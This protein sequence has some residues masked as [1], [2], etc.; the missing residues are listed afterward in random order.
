MWIDHNFSA[1]FC[2]RFAADAASVNNRCNFLLR[3][4]MALA[5][6]PPVAASMDR[7]AGLA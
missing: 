6:V 1:S 2:C 4:R 7:S 3:C 5:G